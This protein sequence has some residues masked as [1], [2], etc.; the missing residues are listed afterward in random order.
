MPSTRSRRRDRKD[1]GNPLVVWRH[2]A[3]TWLAAVLPRWLTRSQRRI[4][5]PTTS[6]PDAWRAMLSRRWRLYRGLPDDLRQECELQIQAFLSG[7]RITGVEIAVTDEVR[8]L[9]AASAAIVSAG[10][11]GFD[12]PQVTEVL[13]YPQS[14]D[15]DDYSF[16]TSAS[17]GQAHPWGIVILSVPTLLRS[18]GKPEDGFHVGIHEFVHLLDLE[19]GEFDGLPLGFGRERSARWERLRAREEKRV[20]QGR[21][22][23]RPYALTNRV[24]FLA[25][26][27][28][29]FFQTP[30]EL[31]Q[32]SPRLYATLADYLRQD[33]AAWKDARFRRNPRPA[34]A[35]RSRYTNGQG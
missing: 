33:P 22:A 7:K 8:V 5:L 4:L 3:A 6:F 21:S 11:A 28:E 12:W 32:S 9:V 25:V 26:A 17:A 19:R 16:A 14:F 15:A 30:V 29:A 10:W 27:A 1:G 18:F 13:V 20:L 34:T 24:E 23:L 2:R 35:P 31:R